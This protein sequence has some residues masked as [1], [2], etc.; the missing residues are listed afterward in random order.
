MNN[1]ITTEKCNKNTINLFKMRRIS[2]T[3][4]VNVY[5]MAALGNTPITYRNMSTNKYI[6]ISN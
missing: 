4:D 5:V 2:L 6:I 1:E 3:N